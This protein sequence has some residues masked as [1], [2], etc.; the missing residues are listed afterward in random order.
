M[1]DRIPLHTWLMVA[2]M[3]AALVAVAYEWKLDG[4]CAAR[5]G[6]LVRG[7]VRPVC[8]D[9]GRATFVVPAR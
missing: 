4:E 8:V 2:I 1:R 9:A 5:G 3:I 6:V 7:A